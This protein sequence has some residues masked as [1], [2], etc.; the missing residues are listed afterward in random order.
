MKK[1]IFSAFSLLVL[2]SN[3]SAQSLTADLVITNANV[4]TIDSKRP[5]ARS[6]AVLGDRIIAVGSDADTKAFIG[7]RTKVIDA[8]GRLVVPGFND[9]HVHFMETG[10]QLSSVD[11]RDAKSPAEFVQRIKD[12]AAKLTA[13]LF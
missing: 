6:I 1:I 8:K 9:A 7:P 2:F 10:A 5:T 13:W 12:F 3:I 11:L 4:H